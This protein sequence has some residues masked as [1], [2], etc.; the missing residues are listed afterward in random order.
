MLCTVEAAEKPARL[1]KFVT[2]ALARRVARPV[3]KRSALGA[4]SIHRVMCK[5]VASVAVRVLLVGAANLV[6][7]VVPM[8]LP[9]AQESVS[10]PK[11]TSITVVR[12]VAV[13]LW[14]YSAKVGR[15]KPFVEARKTPKLVV[16][17]LRVAN[18]A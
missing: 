5:T 16:T 13:V 10:I 7:V 2:Q 15:V 12:V 8:D 11:T 14:D 1:E 3:Q 4:V 17:F 9:C 6:S 18:S